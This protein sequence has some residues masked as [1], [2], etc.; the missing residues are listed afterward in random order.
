M[1]KAPANTYKNNNARTTTSP[2]STR[3]VSKTKPIP[4]TRTKAQND[5]IARGGNRKR[6]DFQPSRQ[7]RSARKKDQGRRGS[8][9]I[10]SFSAFHGENTTNANMDQYGT[11]AVNNRRDA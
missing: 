2:G 8:Q 7:A 1:A 5:Q 3:S 10:K 9:P 4:A 11:E 6:W